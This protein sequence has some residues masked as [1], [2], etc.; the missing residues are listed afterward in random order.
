MNHVELVEFT[1][2][3]DPNQSV[4]RAENFGQYE[5]C[6]VEELTSFHRVLV[7]IVVQRV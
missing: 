1:S 2:K 7:P 6:I 5:A 3:I 4:V